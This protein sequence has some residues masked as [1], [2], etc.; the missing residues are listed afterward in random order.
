MND[1]QEIKGVDNHTGLNETGRGEASD[2]I[3]TEGSF[4]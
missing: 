4:R 2:E 3:L 1:G